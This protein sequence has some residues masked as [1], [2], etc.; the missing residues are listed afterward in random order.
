MKFDIESLKAATAVTYDVVVGHQDGEPGS[1][2]KPAQGDPVGFR[3]VGV[4]SDTYRKVLRECDVLNMQEQAIRKKP[5][6]TSTIE[7]ATQLVEGIEK[8]RD[9]VVEACVQTWFGFPMEFSLENL[10]AVLDARPD[11]RDKILAAI[12]DQGNFSLG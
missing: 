10:R 4:L 9:M 2:G 5:I 8:R 7:G 1:D 6:D 3:V 12:E 11:W